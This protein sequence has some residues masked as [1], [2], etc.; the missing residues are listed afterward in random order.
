[1]VRPLL[2]TSTDREVCGD[3]FTDSHRQE[4]RDLAFDVSNA[5]F[6]IAA[7][8][9]PARR[10]ST[11]MMRHQRLSCLA[12]KERTLSMDPVRP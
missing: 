12:T 5:V 11:S 6:K 9:E 8:M 3:N 2:A 4:M 7:T 1:M 10:P